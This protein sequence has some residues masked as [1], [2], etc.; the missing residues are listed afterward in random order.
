MWKCFQKKRRLHNVGGLVTSGT[1]Y[2]SLGDHG[3]RRTA[4]PRDQ[5]WAPSLQ[6]SKNLPQLHLTGK[7]HYQSTIVFALISI[8]W[9]QECQMFLLS[10][11]VLIFSKCERRPDDRRMLLGPC[12]TWWLH[13]DWGLS[14]QC[15]PREEC[16]EETQVL[17][18]SFL[19]KLGLWFWERNTR[20]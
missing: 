13:A 4:N 2:C 1:P 8:I 7:R 16:T 9:Q 11:P 12:R 20:W 6:L 3:A 15:R 18:L 17:S 5:L 10:P 19:L 14:A